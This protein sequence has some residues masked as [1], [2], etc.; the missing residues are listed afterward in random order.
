VFKSLGLAVE[1]LASAKL[2]LEAQRALSGEI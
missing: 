2:V 1:D